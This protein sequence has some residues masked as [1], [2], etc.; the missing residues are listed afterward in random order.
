MR[1]VVPLAVLC[2]S[3]AWGQ[4]LAGTW[5]SDLGVLTF[6]D[7]GG[8]VTGSGKLDGVLG[9]FTGSGSQGQYRGT[10]RAEGETGTWAARVQGDAAE[11][12][13][14]D[15]PP[16]T[17]ARRGTAAAARGGAAPPPLRAAP[18]APAQAP[19]PATPAPSVGAADGAAYRSDAEGWSLRA[20]AK[21]RY[22]VDG[23]RLVLGS[24][25]EAGMLVATY[26]AG[27][28]FEELQQGA[29]EGFTDSGLVLR[30]SGAPQ[31]LAVPGG[32]A[33]AVD[34]DTT[35]QDGT[36]LR[37]RAAGVAG[38]AGAVVVLGIT[39]PQKFSGLRPRVDQVLKSVAFFQP[40]VPAGANL[41]WGTLCSYS[42]GSV[43]SWTRRLTFDGKGHVAYGSETVAGGRFTDSAG[44]VTGAWGGGGQGEGSSGTYVVSGN[45]VTVR[46]GGE[47]YACG[48]N[49]R[50]NSGRITE[51]TCAGRLY[52]GALC[53]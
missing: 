25:T 50:Q 24:D 43:A 19:A 13:F 41:L 26:G 4:S 16:L 12:T 5:V 38:P 52:A 53:E 14:D 3:L 1:L 35:G 28:T 36:A 31:A 48:V 39:T 49:M 9:A 27:T 30:P 7:S 46:I 47:T 6:S 8:R 33:V 20:P 11:L 37:V 40:K 51:L 15:A 34:M 21:W 17:F 44:A 18:A 42:G 10:Y 32:R 29:T 23:Q 45:T 2:S 22:K